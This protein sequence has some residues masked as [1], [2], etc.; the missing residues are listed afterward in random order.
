VS[1]K[2]PQGSREGRQSFDERRAGGSGSIPALSSTEAALQAFTAQLEGE[3]AA[4]TSRREALAEQIVALTTELAANRAQHCLQEDRFSHATA[5]VSSVV[6]A[7]V[8]RFARPGDPRRIANMVRFLDVAIDDKR[9]RAL[10]LIEF[11]GGM[12]SRSPASATL[13]GE[14]LC[15]G[16]ATL[17]PAF[18]ALNPERVAELLRKF[19]AKA[20]GK[21]DRKGAR[22]LLARLIWDVRGALG[23]SVDVEEMHEVDGLEKIRKALKNRK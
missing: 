15:R 8:P 23:V 17:D 2:L 11:R 1:E 16:L 18:K 10:K 4:A 14:Q 13:W 5:I 7:L 21:A 3:Q 9:Q 6:S 22:S 12:A 19:D 20:K